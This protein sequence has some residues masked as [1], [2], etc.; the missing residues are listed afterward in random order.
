MTG[1]IN[2]KTLPKF[3]VEWIMDELTA[4]T[5]NKGNLRAPNNNNNNNLFI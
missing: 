1:V 5:S 2:T 4:Q 3:N